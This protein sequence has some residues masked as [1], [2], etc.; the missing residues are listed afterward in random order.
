MP[1][2][3]GIKARKDSAFAT[4]GVLPVPVLVHA[5]GSQGPLNM[6]GPLKARTDTAT[7]QVHEARKK[8]HISPI[9]APLA[10]LM[11]G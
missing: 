7:A 11:G 5:E 6:R 10:R 3:R 1:W 9:I 8:H 2:E 4:T